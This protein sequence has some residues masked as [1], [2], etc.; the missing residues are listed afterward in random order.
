[1]PISMKAFGSGPFEVR[2]HLR[3]GGRQVRGPGGVRL[4]ARGQVGIWTVDVH[5]GI[6]VVPVRIAARPVGGFLPEQPPVD[7]CQQIVALELRGIIELRG[8]EAGGARAPVF[9]PLHF[10]L[11][12]RIAPV[13]PL[14]VELV[15][16]L[17]DGEVRIG[18]KIAF[19]PLVDELRP[20]GARGRGRRRP[21]LLLAAGQGHRTQQQ[22]G[23][24]G[25]CH[26]PASA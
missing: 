20:L 21:G 6:E 11:Q 14:A 4:H 3:G 19:D 15:P 7:Q 23:Q 18:R 24:C 22:R 16:P 1:M 2:L 9:Q 17:V 10:G 13:G 8:I 5:R 12:A 25:H 26:F